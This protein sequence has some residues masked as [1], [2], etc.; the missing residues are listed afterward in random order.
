MK[1]Q[2]PTA[3]SRLRRRGW[4]GFERTIVAVLWLVLAGL[5]YA[6]LAGG[7]VASHPAI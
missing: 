6:L 1:Q 2:Q 3:A 7:H 5:R 4:R